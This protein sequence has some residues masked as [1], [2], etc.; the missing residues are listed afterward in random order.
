MDEWVIITKECLE[1]GSSENISYEK[2]AGYIEKINEEIKMDPYNLIKELF[3][4]E[5]VDSDNKKSGGLVSLDGEVSLQRIKEYLSQHR[6]LD[7]EYTNIVLNDLGYLAN[8]NCDINI[9]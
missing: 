7:A 9:D 5:K 6:F 4:S 8:Q 2:F 3:C 1:E